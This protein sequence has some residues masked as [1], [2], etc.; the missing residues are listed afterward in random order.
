MTKRK[1]GGK[2]AN[3]WLY[4]PFTFVV[5]VRLHLFIFE[6]WHILT[7]FFFCSIW[8]TTPRLCLFMDFILKSKQ[9]GKRMSQNTLSTSRFAL[10]RFLESHLSLLIFFSW[11]HLAFILQNLTPLKGLHSQ[12]NLT[13][14][15][16]K[17]IPNFV[18]QN[19]EKQTA[20][21]P[22]VWSTARI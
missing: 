12:A 5:N 21:Q 13:S 16:R 4:L 14:N 8:S 10:P 9:L 2:I 11:R 1:N 3:T 6:F 17:K 22:Q 18:L 20:P 7:T 15:H 19:I